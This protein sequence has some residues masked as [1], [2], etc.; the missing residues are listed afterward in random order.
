MQKNNIAIQ[1]VE[2]IIG[3]PNYKILNEYSSC[4]PEYEFTKLYYMS[5]EWTTIKLETDICHL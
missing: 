2:E 3:V 5:I 1:G 4:K